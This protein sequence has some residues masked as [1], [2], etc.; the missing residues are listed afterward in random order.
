MG[1]GTEHHREKNPGTDDYK[2][3]DPDAEQ[4]KRHGR[5]NDKKE[6]GGD[7]LLARNLAAMTETIVSLHT[8][9][10]M[11][12]QKTAS[13]AYH[14]V[15]MEEILTEIITA[16]GLSLAT[17]NARI[18]ARNAGGTDNEGGPDLAIDVAASIASLTPRY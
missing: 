4:R 11:L 7:D 2:G 16:N 15:A 13:M 5:E 17:V 3:H 18:R 6:V 12:V 8:T 9:I 14:I 10:D 1:H